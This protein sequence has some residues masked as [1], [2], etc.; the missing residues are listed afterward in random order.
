M[1][2]GVAR[3]VYVKLCVGVPVCVGRLVWVPLGET[4]VLLGEGVG[5]MGLL[6]LLRET[7]GGRLGSTVRDGVSGGVRVCEADGPGASF[8]A[9]ATLPCSPEI[10]SIRLDRK[11]LK[12]LDAPE[13]LI[14][15]L[16]VVLMRVGA[17]LVTATGSLLERKCQIAAPNAIHTIGR[18]K[19]PRR[20][21]MS[22]KF[23]SH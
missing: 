16:V 4:G 23:L 17:L 22:N 10:V 20:R 11:S 13:S 5:G 3:E 8:A 1:R 7:S 14:P 21:A 6:E 2:V 15:P 12:T 18:W 9:A 19:Q